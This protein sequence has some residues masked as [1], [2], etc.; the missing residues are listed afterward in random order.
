MPAAANDDLLFGVLAVRM[1]FVTAAS[2]AAQVAG[3]GRLAERLAKAGVLSEPRRRLVEG[4]AA[5]HL[6][7]H[8]GDAAAALRSLRPDPAVHHRLAADAD[9]DIDTL[10]TTTAAQA[11]T[12]PPDLAAE[13]PDLTAEAAT[14][15][16]AAGAASTVGFVAAGDADAGGRSS[17]GRYR[18]LAAHARGG[19]GQVSR[20]ADGEL[21]REV[22]LKEILP[23]Y[24]ADPAVRERFLHEAHVTGYLEHPGVV[25]IYGLHDG[26]RPFHAM[27]CV[28]GHSRKDAIRARHQADADDPSDLREL[29]VRFVDVCQAMAYAHSRGV[30][31]R[32]LKP[33]N[34]M[35]GPFGESLVVDWG[36]AKRLGDAEPAAAASPAAGGGGSSGTETQA[37]Q[38]VGTPAYMS[39]EQATGDLG[40]LG[41]ATDV[42]A[43]GGVLAAI[44]TGQPPVHGQR[45]RRYPRQGVRGRHPR[46][47]PLPRGR[48]QGALGGLPQ[49]H[50]PGHR[51][52]LRRRRGAG[53][54]DRPFPRRRA[55]PGL[56]GAVARPR[57]ALA[58]SS[59]CDH[60]RAG[61][62]PAA[63]SGRRRRRRRTGRRLQPSA[64]RE[65]RGAGHAEGRTGRAEP[66]AGGRHRRRAGGPAAGGGE[67]RH[68]PG[69]GRRRLPP[70]RRQREAEG[71]L[72]EKGLFG[73]RKEL[74]QA[75]EPFCRRLTEQQP[76]DAVVRGSQA[77]AWRN[78][79]DLHR[80]TGE[81]TAAQRECQM[82]L[83]LHAE[84][85]AGDPKQARYRSGMYRAESLS[86]AIFGE[87]RDRDAAVGAARRALRIV[88]ELAERSPENEDYRRTVAFSYAN[89]A[90]KLK[91]RC[92]KA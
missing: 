77:D 56:R 18:V 89:L 79:A 11:A 7:T 46:R 23:H 69:R 5:E 4:V 87:Q 2:L 38:A 1:G 55:G 44:L 80:Q 9:A 52:P 83:S 45:A 92:D 32:D 57:P 26:S 10:P 47:R 65:E 43:L 14:L 12:L 8:A 19:L 60:R 41:P 48:F 20:A 29:L 36:L 74:L 35:L 70:R 67:L 85:H 15:P 61:R 17:H 16:P 59:S 64:G 76:T 51:R 39:P 54:R 73:L 53:R 71:K 78:L 3:E 42:Y 22:A 90:E 34:V 25:P 72:K 75:A 63:G 6:A 86:S 21:H 28:R 50:E 62:R 91:G 82:S 58:A 27:R 66:V 88:V 68:R 84:M 31:H 37:G 49:G 24:A 81:L 40:R 33:D 13:T 30:I